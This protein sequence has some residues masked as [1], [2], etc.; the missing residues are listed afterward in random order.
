[1]QRIGVVSDALETDVDGILARGSMQKRNAKLKA[2]R[3]LMLY[4][5]TMPRIPLSGGSALNSAL[6]PA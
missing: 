4:I 5:A 6:L 3:S 1:M 2:L